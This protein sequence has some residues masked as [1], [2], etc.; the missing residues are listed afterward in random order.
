CAVRDGP[1]LPAVGLCGGSG[2]GL[3]MPAFLIKFVVSPLL[4]IGVVVW[5]FC[6]PSPRTEDGRVL[7]TFGTFGTPEQVRMYEEIIALFEQEHPHIKVHLR[8]PSSGGYLAK[9]QVELA[10]HVAPDVT[11]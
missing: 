9:L 11:W 3:I 8:T 2:Q 5:L 6:T 4:M 10:G 1:A 7:I